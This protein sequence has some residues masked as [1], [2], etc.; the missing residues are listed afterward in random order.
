[1]LRPST[2]ISEK[3][4]QK[5][6]KDLVLDAAW[7]TMTGALS[8]GVVLVAF[9]LSLGAGPMIIGLL[10]A[11]PFIAQ[12]AQ[13]PS[14]ALIEH[15][16]KRK[17]VGVVVIT[18]SRIVI[19]LL[20]FIPFIPDKR[21]ALTL[22]IAGQ[23]AI[24]L[25]GSICACAVNSWLHQLI[26]SERRGAFFAKRLLW[27]T[28]MGVAGSLIAGQFIE[29]ATGE[30]QVFAF[31]AC[32]FVSAMAGFT[33]SFYLARAPEPQMQGENLQGFISVLKHP[34]RDINFRRL[35]IFLGSW[36]VASNI[37]APF[38][39]VYLLR[40]LG[41]S[42]WMVMILGMAGQ[43]ANAITLYWWG[44]LS[45]RFSNKN[46]LW[47]ALPIYFICTAAFVL[48]DQPN[49][50][51]LGLTLLWV[52]HVLMGAASGGIG[53]ATGNLG[54]KLAPQG[55]GTA[56]LAMVGIV[57]SVAGGVA[58][59]AAGLAAT[60][61]ETQQLS[62]LIR[63]TSAVKSSE[64]AVFAFAHWEFLFLISALSGLYVIHCLTRVK[65]D[66]ELSDQTLV[67]QFAIEAARTVVNSSSVGVAL[68]FL[69]PF[70]RLTHWRT[71]RFQKPLD[72]P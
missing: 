22:L 36:T 56:Y 35:L 19:L 40:Q 48:A 24:A 26:P 14:I 71:K 57:S 46:V 69:F 37:A 3:D 28:L 66:G 6:E 17:R 47:V 39:A 67:Q 60:W 49:R 58:P 54:L 70:R 18:T 10:S 15:V 62:L 25:L 61:F 8:G 31:A 42:V 52:L 53:L 9:A 50:P 7:A 55:Q 4:L 43:L 11:I 64:V 30:D 45:D 41:Y 72:P 16:R 1:M 27:G 20:V 2:C 44:Q 21:I 23:V 5:G 34:L 59:L 13:L 51:W 12:I 63:W 33:S 68:G 29:N 32:F 65:E 38:L